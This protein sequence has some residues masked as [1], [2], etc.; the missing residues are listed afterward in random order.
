MIDI[1]NISDETVRLEH[2]DELSPIHI[3]A[4]D[5]AH[6]LTQ[7][8]SLSF[9]RSV[10]HSLFCGHVLLAAPLMVQQ[11]NWALIFLGVLLAQC[12]IIVKY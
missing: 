4:S 6:R 3:V 5:M 10:S 1:D 9:C 7:F 2:F 8:I 11:C 12:V